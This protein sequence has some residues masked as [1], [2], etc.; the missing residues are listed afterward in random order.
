VFAVDSTVWPNMKK[1]AQSLYLHLRWALLIAVACVLKRRR[2]SLAGAS[3]APRNILFIRVDRIG[4]MVVSTPALRAIK[5]SFPGANLTVLASR[6]NAQLLRHDPFVDRVMLWDGVRPLGS[7]IGFLRR[8]NQLARA[9]FD[10]VID[11]MT[12][13][14][15]RT[16]LIAWLSRAPMRI[17]YAGYGREV[18]FNHVCRPGGDR[19][20]VDLILDVTQ[21][22]GARPDGRTPQVRLLPIELEQAR[23]RLTSSGSAGR[24]LVAIHPGAHYPSQRWPTDYFAR[25]AQGLQRDHSCRVIL[26]GGPEDG[27]LIKKIQDSAGLDLA[28]FERLDVRQTAAM[29]AHAD[30]LVCN[31]SGPLHLAAAV[32]TPT[33]S[34]MGPTDRDRWMPAGPGHV[35]LR[36]DRLD[37]IGCNQGTCARSD[38]P[39]MRMTTPD[40]ALARLWPLLRQGGVATG[41][42]IEGGA[43]LK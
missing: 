43:L 25:M 3:L 22:L 15:L 27:T 13:H 10:A 23:G 9:R 8:A 11:P 36:Q 6:A 16:A 2:R 32:G 12:G 5:R 30:V 1:L 14:D 42:P 26:L 28:T 39:C 4:D 33:L 19:L 24:P 31:N 29:I 7:P 18:F 17:G 38:H 21:P 34:F 40:T 41:E 37:C 20:M 35:V